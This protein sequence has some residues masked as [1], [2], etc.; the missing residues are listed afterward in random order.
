M[1]NAGEILRLAELSK[2]ERGK[3]EK[4]WRDCYRATFPQMGT[5]FNGQTDDLTAETERAML[6]DSTGT[7]A[8]RTLASVLMSG[9]TPANSRWLALEA[10][11]GEEN[12]A[13]NAWLAECADKVWR[14]IHSANFDSTAFDALLELVIS[15]AFCL[16]VDT[17]RTRGGFL[18]E[19]WPAYECYWSRVD[20]AR[21]DTIYRFTEKTAAELVA[22]YGEDKVSEKVRD[23]MRTDPN[24]KVRVL[25]AIGPRPNARPGAKLAK[26]MPYYSAHIECDSKSVLRESG[27]MEFPVLVPRFRKL[28][29]SEYA[30]GPVSDALPD[31]NELNYLKRVERAS[32]EMAIA[33]MY[34]AVDDGVLNPRTIRVGAKQVIIANDINSIKPLQTG[35][36]FNIAFQTEE[37]LQAQ[38]RR[39]LMADQLQPQ[40]NRAMTATEVNERMALI[41]QQLGPAFGRLQAE[42]L[43]PLVE[44]CFMIMY[45]AGALPEAPD[46][47]NGVDFRA[48]YENP[49]ARAQKLGEVTA[50]GQLVGQVE[51]MAQIWPETADVLDPEETIRD[52]GKSL[53]VPAHLVRTTEQIMQVRDRRA[54]AQAAAQQQQVEQQAQ[55][56]NNSAQIQAAA[57]QQTQGA[58]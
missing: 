23:S 3:Y 20:S 35:A 48:K 56:E 9:L 55:I 11:S 42:Y 32:A 2:A 31:I 33:G 16:L 53:G 17:D 13:V 45:R 38:I 47:I 50:I 26:N 57:Q 44:R 5:G 58:A 24:V 10:T 49:L 52:L 46:A 19:Q 51:Q 25:I 18:F 1:V 41:R 34:V 14:N 7:D 29:G 12:D 30:I 21:V 28:P 8:A 22:T 37:R 15:G 43:T 4:H 54:K 36:N 27:F 6:V 39:V 40:G